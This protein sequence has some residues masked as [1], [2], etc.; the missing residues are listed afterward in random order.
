M[1]QA[2]RSTIL[3]L[4][5]EVLQDSLSS[6]KSGRSALSAGP[7][8]EVLSQLPSDASKLA[9]VNAGGA[10]QLADVHICKSLGVRADP[11]RNSLSQLF[12]QLAQACGKTTVQVRTNE[13]PN[14]FNLNY[15]INNIPQLGPIFPL[16]AQIPAAMENPMLAATRPSPA[17]KAMVR[18][19]AAVELNWAPG[20]GATAHKVYFGTSIDKLSLLGEVE[21]PSYDELP[22]PERGITYYWRVD[23]VRVDGSIITGDIWSF[24][25]GKLV[26]WWKFDEKAG[27]TVADSSGNDYHGT[28]VH[29]N[30]IWNPDGKSD[31]FFFFTSMRFTVFQSR[32]RC[33]AASIRP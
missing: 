13:K 18:P 16:L 9:V 8:Q 17:D 25:A 14:N 12:G 15:G 19:T 26:A 5:P 20:G 24:G 28:M 27:K 10:M 31:V 32:K 1:G 23:E 29:G 6:L 33:L 11:N 3:T 2:G 7:L 4:S 30:P 21:T 22:T